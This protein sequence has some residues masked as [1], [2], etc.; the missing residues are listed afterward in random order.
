MNGLN[1]FELI[2]TGRV[3]A[4]PQVG[5]KGEV[6]FALIGDDYAGKEREP[7]VT[8]VFFVAFAAIGEAIARNARTGD[9]L[10]VRAQ[11]QSSNY[12]KGG[13]LVYSYSFVVQGF[14]FGAPGNAK[15]QALEDRSAA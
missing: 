14:K 7:I 12:K 3:A 13:K 11:M 1:S 9:Q 5:D 6:K 10:I 2:A 15:R 8:S 4:E